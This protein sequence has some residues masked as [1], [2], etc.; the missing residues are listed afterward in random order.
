M[1]SITEIRRIVDVPV[2]L[3]FPAEPAK[4]EEE[5]EPID[6]EEAAA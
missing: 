5:S 3:P 6:V 4:I 1:S 2:E